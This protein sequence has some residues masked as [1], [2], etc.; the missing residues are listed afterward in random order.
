MTVITISRQLGSGGDVIAAQV[1]EQLGYRYF[2]KE[3]MVEAA[4]NVGL[5][6]NEIVDFTED[7][8][9]VQDF[10]SRLLRAR[11]R[12]VK[13]LLVR[14]EQHGLIETLTLR[15]LDEEDCVALVRYTIERV[16]EEDNIVILGRGGQAILKDKPNVV[17]VRIFAPLEARSQRLRARGMSGVSEIKNTIRDSDRASA[18][19]LKRFFN[20]QWDDP[21]HYHM[22]LNTGLLDTDTAAETIIATARKLSTAIV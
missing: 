22:I 8:Y 14:E 10:I 2:D 12:T 18:E 11:P 1:C 4:A 13:E 6:E 17:H 16:Y 21:E 7:R 5:C 3:M 19:F 20:I 9:K 15:E